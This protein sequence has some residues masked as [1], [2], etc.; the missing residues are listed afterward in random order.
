RDREGAGTSAT[1]ETG[2]ELLLDNGLGGFTSDGR[3]Y[4]LHPGTLP[5]APW[6]NVVSNP[7]C[8]FL[9]TDNGPGCTWVGNSQTNR[10]TPWRNDPV[11]DPLGEV[12]YVRDEDSGEVWSATPGPEGGIPTTVRHGHGYSVFGQQRDGLEQE[13]T[14]FVPREDPVK[15][16][17]IR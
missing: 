15:I 10:L 2:Q 3:E 8:G 7:N 1:S 4:V 16:L 5:P 9:V 6:I 11:T 14:L 13:L 17:H 12:V